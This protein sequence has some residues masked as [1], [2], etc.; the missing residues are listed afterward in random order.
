LIKVIKVIN[1]FK[2][3]L[4]EAKRVSWPKKDDVNKTVI[5]IICSIV[6]FAVFFSLMDLLVY[7]V[8]QFFIGL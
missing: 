8:V 4:Y 1:F 7:N 2:E 6:F 5:L 3:A